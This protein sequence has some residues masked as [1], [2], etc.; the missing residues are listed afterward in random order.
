MRKQ[1]GDNSQSRWRP[2]TLTLPK[3]RGLTVPQLHSCT[4]P[5]HRTSSLSL[6]AE[7]GG[8]GAAI[9]ILL[10]QR[11]FMFL[12]V[13]LHKVAQQQYGDPHQPGI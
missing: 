6:W 12:Q 7:V 10:C 3:E 4:G 13:N 5:Q 9:L 2:L 11:R 8:E 1:S